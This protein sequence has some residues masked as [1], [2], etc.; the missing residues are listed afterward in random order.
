MNTALIIVDIQ[1]DYFPNGKNPLNNPENAANNAK[2]V[3][4]W[5]RSNHSENIFHIQHIAPDD[6]FGFFAPNTKGIEIHEAV[7]PIDGE[8]IINKQL[9]N[10][11]VNT[12]LQEKLQ[13]KNI[14]HVVVV[15]MMT[16]MC[17][18]A[19]VRAAA[20]LGY[21]VTLIEDACASS[22]LTYNDHIISAQ[23]VHYSFISALGFGYAEVT[24]AED[25]VK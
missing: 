6:S 14:D 8:T 2:K 3:L 7:K 16:H 21:G 25:F 12:D 24:T 15:G 13:E 19:T 23:D 5:F 9:P 20:D 18:D 22:E 11:F 4:T 17:I 10:S 1:E